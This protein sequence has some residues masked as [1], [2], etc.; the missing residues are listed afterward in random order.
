MILDQLIMGVRYL[1]IRIGL[2][3][4]TYWVN[5][6]SVT[7]HPLSHILNQVK[8]YM[9]HTEEIVIIDFHRFP[10]GNK[11]NNNLPIL[12]N[13]LVLILINVNIKINVHC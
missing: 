6:G 3:N 8:H 4:N 2:Y 9:D 12:K 1:D 13:L 7:L 5:R 10:V 11:N